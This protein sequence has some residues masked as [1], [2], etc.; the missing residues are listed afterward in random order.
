MPERQFIAKIEMAM[1]CRGIGGEEVRVKCGC[2]QRC[3]EGVRPGVRSLSVDYGAG[4]VEYE[5]KQGRHCRAPIVGVAA[6][7]P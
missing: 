6:A 4:S 5:D 2:M 7:H 1:G 3:C